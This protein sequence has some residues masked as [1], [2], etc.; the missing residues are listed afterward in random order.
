MGSQKLNRGRWS[1]RKNATSVLYST[2]TIVIVSVLVSV[3]MHLC[4]FIISMT[5]CITGIHQIIKLFDYHFLNSVR[6]CNTVG[7]G[8]VHQM[9]SCVNVCLGVCV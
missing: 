9:C 5:L 1:R 6:V 4:L 2:L 7:V 8:V 3:R